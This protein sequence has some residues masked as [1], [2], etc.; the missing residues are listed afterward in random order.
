MRLLDRINVFEPGLR[1]DGNIP[2]GWHFE[3]LR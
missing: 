1:V 3:V 2:K